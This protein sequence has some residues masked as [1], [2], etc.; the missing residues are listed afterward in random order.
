MFFVDDIHVRREIVTRKFPQSVFKK[1]R[2]ILL[3][4][5]LLVVTIV[6]V[7][8]GVD[9][10]LSKGVANEVGL[11]WEAS[12]ATEL[13]KEYMARHVAV[14]A[15]NPHHFNSPDMY[16]PEKPEGVSKRIAVLG[17]SFV[18]GDGLPDAEMIWSRR[19]KRR[20]EKSYPEVQVLEWGLCGW[21]TRDQLRFL[22]SIEPEHVYDID[23]LVIGFVTN[24]PDMGDKEQKYIKWDA[25]PLYLCKWLPTLYRW[26]QPYVERYVYENFS[27]YGYA[28]W[29]NHLY[30]PQNLENYRRLLL[31][32]KE[33]LD[34]KNIPFFFVFTPNTP[35]NRFAEL[36]KPI[37]EL[38]DSLGI[39]YI[40]LYP[41]VVEKFGDLPRSQ[42]PQKL[43]ANPVNG[44]PG[45]ALTS[46]Y[47]DE[48]YAHIQELKW[49]P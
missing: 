7:L 24:D 33:F 9:Y 15:K 46:V 18:W 37:R 43:Y 19:L 8:V 21:S 10:V 22:K 17:D 42:W 25:C 6:L 3:N 48:T 26:I 47:A 27:D 5:S 23:Y 38:F 45:P 12:R 2:S 39:G 49:L 32:L 41:V 16:A 28:N 34:S 35:N 1:V 44:H 14:A 13:N 20:I 31:D 29:E 11:P 40:D 36:Y 4:I 30:S